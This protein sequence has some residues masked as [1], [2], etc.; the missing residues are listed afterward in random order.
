M[1][2]PRPLAL[3]QDP[4]SRLLTAVLC[5]FSHGHTL[6]CQGLLG[7]RKAILRTL[8]LPP[9]LEIVREEACAAAADLHQGGS[10]LWEWA[11]QEPLLIDRL[12]LSPQGQPASAPLWF[13]GSHS[14]LEKCSQRGFFI[15]EESSRY[16][17]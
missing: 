9:R 8:V 10:L 1:P 11:W 15:N 7:L 6:A 4:F 12:Q 3:D 13:R 2:Q 14:G 17:R 16:K 5:V